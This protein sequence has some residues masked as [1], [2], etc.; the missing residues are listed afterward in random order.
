MFN[1]INWLDILFVILLLGMVYKGTKIGVGGQIIALIG[2]F[3]IVF[4]SI[5]YYTVLSEAIFGFLL[6][7]WA[8]PVSFFAI[9]LGVFTIV[10]TAERL[11]QVVIGEEVSAL[12]KFVGALIAGVRAAMLFGVLGMILVLTPIQYTRFAALEGSKTCKVFMEM[13]VS[14]YCWMT[15]GLPEDKQRG[16]EDVMRELKEVVE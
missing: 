7:R 9:V 1:N 4:V 12:E 15:S 13:D 11:S 3:T 2:G 6:Q 5:S 10:K 14:I 8:K 16:K